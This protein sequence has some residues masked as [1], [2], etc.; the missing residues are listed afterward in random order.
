V[1]VDPSRRRRRQDGVHGCGCAS[2]RKLVR[3]SLPPAPRHTGRPNPGSARPSCSSRWGLSQCRSGSAARAGSAASN[4]TSAGRDVTLKCVV[5]VVPVIVWPW[6]LSSASVPTGWSGVPPSVMW[7]SCRPVRPRSTR[8]SGTGRRRRS[9]PPTPRR[10]C[11]PP[12]RWPGWSDSRDGAAAAG[13][14]DPRVMERILPEPSA[15]PLS[16][17]QR[18]T[19][20]LEIGLPDR[21]GV[22]VR[23]TAHR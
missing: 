13:G 4:V 14:S 2:G 21:F 20:P 15:R 11:A 23:V 5:S 17:A 7:P 12:R 16:C 18:I 6:H 19:T 1:S 9:R 3:R 8:R 10:W 22:R